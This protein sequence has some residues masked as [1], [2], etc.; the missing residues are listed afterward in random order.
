MNGKI[1]NNRIKIFSQGP[2]YVFVKFLSDLLEQ[3]DGVICRLHQFLIVHFMIIQCL[4]DPINWV[5][6]TC[7]LLMKSLYVTSRYFHRLLPQ[8]KWIT[9]KITF[10][11]SM[12]LW[13][14]G[15]FASNRKI[16]AWWFSSLFKN[17]LPVRS[18]N[19]PQ[20]INTNNL[21]Y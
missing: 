18:V 14:R 8:S 10:G 17:H 7:S 15:L 12:F 13:W 5:P 16:F 19:P 20:L 3:I 11:H 2:I 9:L 21:T 1:M 4:L 6:N